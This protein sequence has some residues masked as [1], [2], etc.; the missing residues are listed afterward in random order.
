MLFL[1]LLLF[2]PLAN[3]HPEEPASCKQSSVT[4]VTLFTF[5][6]IRDVQNAKRL[7]I[8]AQND[9]QPIR[10]TH[11]GRK[12][13][14][15]LNFCL[16][17]YVCTKKSTFNGSSR[18]FV[19]HPSILQT[20]QTFFGIYKYFADHLGNFN[21]IWKLFRSSGRFSDYL[22]TFQI[23]W[24]LYRSFGC[25]SDYLG[26]FHIIHSLSGSSGHFAHRPDSLQIIQL[27][28]DHTDTPDYLNTL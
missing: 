22:D 2:R 7:L 26:T 8:R 28:L 27:L 11:M 17:K 10:Y 16:A 12:A 9:L 1:F 25:S 14:R 21:T 4:P 19:D 5:A 6:R 13:R 15:N 23:I 18:H 24:T 20:I 3:D